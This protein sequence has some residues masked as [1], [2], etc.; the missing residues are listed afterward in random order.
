M[1]MKCS[2]YIFFKRILFYRKKGHSVITNVY[3]TRRGNV[4]YVCSCGVNETVS[5]QI[6]LRNCGCLGCDKNRIS[7]LTNERLDYIIKNRNIKRIGSCVGGKKAIKFK[8]LIDKFEWMAKPNNIIC[9]QTGCP[10]CNKF[11]NSPL[12]D[13]GIDLKLKGRRIKR[14]GNSSGN[15]NKIEWKC[16]NPLCLENW[17]AIPGSVLNNKTGCPNCSCGKSEKNVKRLIQH[18]IIYDYFKH[19]KKIYIPN[20]IIPDFYLEIGN[21]KVIIEYN[22]HQHYMPRT[23]GGISKKE[24]ELNFKNQKERDDKVR[25]YCQTNNIYLLEIPYFWKEAQIIKGLELINHFH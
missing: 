3:P 10:K 16:L 22:G 14:I 20:L 21:K 2:E 9:G 8:C 1:N 12:T 17:F 4:S 5:M 11:N 13:R 18:R 6:F 19:H 24:A 25:T 15:K 23:F 7:P